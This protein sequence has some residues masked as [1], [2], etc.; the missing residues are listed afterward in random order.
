MFGRIRNRRDAQKIRKHG[1]LKAKNE[2]CGVDID[3]LAERLS[4]YGMLDRYEYQDMYRGR[5]D[6][7]VKEICRMLEDPGSMDMVISDIEGFLKEAEDWIAEDFRAWGMHKAEVLPM[8]FGKRKPLSDAKKR[9]YIS[10]AGSIASTM[11][12]PVMVMALLNEK[13]GVNWRRQ[14]RTRSSGSC[15]SRTSATAW[16]TLD[17]IP[18]L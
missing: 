3:D 15:V 16:I 2:R 11:S 13:P 4:I 7:Y 12:L 8:I 6:E 17:A 18:G 9:Q 1:L 14:I 10:M 5:E